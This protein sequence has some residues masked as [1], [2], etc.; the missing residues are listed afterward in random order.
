MPLALPESGLDRRGNDHLCRRAAPSGVT[1][2]QAQ[3]ELARVSE[4]LNSNIQIPT[5]HRGTGSPLKESVVR[6]V[7]PAVL[8]LMSAVIFVLL[9]ASSN[10]AHLLLTRSVV[11]AREF[12]VRRALGAGTFRLLRQLIIES[13]LLMTLCA[14]PGFL[15][16]I[17]G[18]ESVG[19]L[20]RAVSTSHSSIPSRSERYSLYDAISVLPGIMPGTDSGVV[21]RAESTSLRAG[22]NGSRDGRSPAAGGFSD[23]WLSRKPPCHWRCWLGPDD[24][25]ESSATF[26]RMDQG[27]DQPTC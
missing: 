14:V 25:A 15:L 1:V 3:Q 11:R 21:M 13:L 9:I 7:R 2:G 24:V 10:V 27:F 17:W 19:L 4:D 23:F 22:W 6:G 26:K 20:I 5:E 18:T 8:L 16:T 12:A